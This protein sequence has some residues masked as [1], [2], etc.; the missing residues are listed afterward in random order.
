MLSSG[1]CDRQWTQTNRSNPKQRKDSVWMCLGVFTWSTSLYFLT[2]SLNVW[3]W[4]RA[5]LFPSLTLTSA[6]RQHQNSSCVHSFLP[7]SL[8]SHEAKRIDTH[9]WRHRWFYTGCCLCWSLYLP[10]VGWPG[11]GRSCQCWFWHGRTCWMAVGRQQ[12]RL[13]LR[14]S[15]NIDVWNPE[16]VWMNP[17][18]HLCIVVIHREVADQPGVWVI[19]IVGQDLSHGRQVQH[20]PLRCRPHSL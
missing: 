17:L 10:L 16:W 14:I 9:H 12:Q 6:Y 20:V 15:I 2:I 1:C 3:N 8:M 19:L 5:G 7:W 11:S 4:M 13:W 18:A